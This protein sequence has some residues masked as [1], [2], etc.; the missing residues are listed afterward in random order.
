MPG[1]QTTFNGR[2]VTVT[3]NGSMIADL[4]WNSPTENLANATLIAAAPDLLAAL[5]AIVS[6]SYLR[7]GPHED[8]HVHPDL[9]EQA[10]VA[11]TSARAAATPESDGDK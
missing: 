5:K 3:A 9:I 8:C 7:D 10:R 2:R 1:G 6:K 11:L 4:D